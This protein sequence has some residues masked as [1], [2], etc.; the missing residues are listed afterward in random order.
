MYSIEPR[1]K[2]DSFRD[3]FGENKREN[4]MKKM[5]IMM[6]IVAL[7]LGA[8]AEMRDWTIVSGTV[9]KGEFESMKDYEGTMTVYITLEDGKLRGIPLARLVEEDQALAKQLAGE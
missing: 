8:L 4:R 1:R 3:L 6:A 7:A 9:L 5:M 2:Q